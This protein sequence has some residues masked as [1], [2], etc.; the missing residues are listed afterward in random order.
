[1]EK[2]PRM[3]PEFRDVPDE[4]NGFLQIIL[5]SESLKGRLLP[6]DL[7]AC[8]QGESAWDGQAFKA[9]LG[10]NQ[11]V[12]DKILCTAELPDH[13]VK[14]LALDRLASGS[15]RPISDF[16]LIL[17]SAARLAFESEDRVTALRYMKASTAL[18][19]HLVEI[20]SPTMLGEV[21]SLGIRLDVRDSFWENFLPGLASDPE[22]LRQWK[23]AVFTDRSPAEDYSRVMIG[24]WNSIMRN[25]YLPALLGDPAAGGPFPGQGAFH[26]KNVEGFL[27][28]CAT[29]FLTPADGILDL[30]SDRFN[31]VNAGFEA[32]DSALDPGS[33]ELIA[34]TISV[35]RLIPQSLAIQVTRTAK[36]AA[37]ISIL[38]GETP[39][40]DPV[41]GKPF[42]WDPDSRLLSAPEGIPGQDPLQ[43]P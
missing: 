36:H 42:L 19:D 26:V 14:G 7:R 28:A 24:E 33:S 13:S 8:L 10:E 3:K 34:N 23:E 27:D 2:Y 22:T 37:A 29:L 38:L 9:W 31:L 15:N 17:H 1:L 12:F 41:S 5:L 20:E 16:G 39:P 25:S 43:V 30:G 35:F 11:E 6:D 40:V 4:Q 21:L 32:P 18:A